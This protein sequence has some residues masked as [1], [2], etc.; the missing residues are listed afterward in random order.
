MNMNLSQFETKIQINKKYIRDRKLKGY[1]TI[2]MLNEI[3][4]LENDLSN[5]HR[6]LRKKNRHA[7]L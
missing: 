4:K 6:K 2:G 7:Y 5:Y 1:N 3:D